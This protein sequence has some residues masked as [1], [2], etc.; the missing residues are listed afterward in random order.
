[1]VKKKVR[2][3]ERRRR[4]CTFLR[5]RRNASVGTSYCPVSVSCLRLSVTSRCSIEIDGRIELV[6]GCR[7]LSTDRIVGYNNVL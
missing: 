3:G 4:D 1:M 2:M 6:L 5:A 7:L